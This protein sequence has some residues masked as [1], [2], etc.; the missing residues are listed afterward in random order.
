MDE[1][2]GDGRLE[3]KKVIGHG[4]SAGDARSQL[5]RKLADAWVEA[6]VASPLDDLC[7]VGGKGLCEA[8]RLEIDAPDW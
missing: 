6:T 3:M 2:A 7:E 5:E 1:G 8:T 4:S